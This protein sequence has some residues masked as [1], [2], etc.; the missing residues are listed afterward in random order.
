M[1]LLMQEEEYQTTYETHKATY[2]AAMAEVSR[3][4]EDY[5][6]YSSPK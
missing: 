1:E 4:R 3:I 6:R 5:R 2:E